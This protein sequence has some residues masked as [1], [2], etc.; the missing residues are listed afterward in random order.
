M[1]NTKL[2]D[3]FFSFSNKEI[4]EFN[5]FVHSPYFNRR[6]E[7]I[8]LFDYL[9]EH[10]DLPEE[11]LSKARAWKYVFPNSDYED[12]Q[13][14]YTMSFLLKTM[15]DF[16]VQKELSKDESYTQVLFCRAL[17]QRGVDNLFEKEMSTTIDKQERQAYRNAQFHYNN[18][19]L[20]I[21]RE[22]YLSQKV[23]T[24]DPEL[25]K[26]VDELTHFYISDM[27]RQSCGALSLQS[28]VQRDYTLN[29]LNEVLEHV[30]LRDYSDMPAIGIYFHGYKALSDLNDEK[31]FNQLKI[32]IEK[33]W[34]KFPTEESRSIYVLAINCGIKRLNKGNRKYIRE[35]F[36]LYKSGLENKVLLE[37]G[38]LSKYTYT[39]ASRSALA[40][41]E[42]SWVESFLKE[43][44]PYLPSSERE[45][46]YNF[47]LAFYYF[48]KPDYESAM[49]LLQK[50]DFKDVLNNLDSRRML[51]RIYYELGYYDAL[52]SLLDSF[53]VYLSRQKNIGY[54]KENYA[55]LIQ[56]VKKILRTNLNDKTKKLKLVNEIEAT[57]AV[58]EKAWLLEQLT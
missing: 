57:P 6:E 53:K 9:V 47:N 10:K 58:A 46:T 15:K 22:T 36:E 45:N 32:L 51:L 55:N 3:V 23:R 14:R 44:K 18:Y 40:L 52:D 12:S 4:K 25:Q 38:M 1:K 41:K 20:Q 50:V 29:F 2:I 27:L 21:E 28:L 5:Q 26:S 7:V 33:H 49:E 37:N 13:M 30:E 34:A 35:C 19:L 17:R 43:Y 16:L 48:Q 54:H 56:F 11:T 39:N 8:R 31:H 42:F 24:S